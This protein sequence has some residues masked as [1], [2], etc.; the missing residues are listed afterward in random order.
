MKLYHSAR[1]SA[2]YRV[3]IALACKGI[4]YESRLLNMQAM[5]HASPEYRLVNPVALVPALDIGER[6]LGQSLAIIEYLEETHPEPRLLPPDALDRAYVR[7]L[8]HLIAC[9]IHPLNNL[10][11]LNFVRKAY[12]QD[13]QGINTWYKHWIADGFSLLESFFAR[14]KRHGRYCN[15]N[16]ISMADCCIVPQVANA[17]RYSCD[18]APYPT[19]MRIHDACIEMPSFIQASPGN[20]GEKWWLSPIEDGKR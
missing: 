12:R 14:E 18:L 13:E 1:S 15:G 20:Q 7:A 3:R 9:E 8:S 2:S 19:V 10:R 17:Q 16:E 6:V 4:P 11:T 5:Q